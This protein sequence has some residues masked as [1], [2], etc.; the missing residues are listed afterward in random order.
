LKEEYCKLREND[1]SG[2]GQN[3][4]RITVRQ[5]E[6]MIRLSE[7]LAK[8]QFEKKVKE[9]HVKEASRL[10]RKSIIHVDTVDLILN[11]NL[12]NFQQNPRNQHTLLFDSQQIDDNED[13]DDTPERI[14]VSYEER[15]K[16]R[17]A[18]IDYFHNSQSNQVPKD[19]LINWYLVN[20][21]DKYDSIKELSHTK[22]IL[23][24][25]IDNLVEEQDLVCTVE[26]GKEIISLNAFL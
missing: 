20:Q 11:E 6:S 18:F 23:I 15:E 16:I 8:L 22:E 24:L 10:L 12:V 5:L 4:Y 1:V 25:V 17:E 2:S 13:M 14:V 21:V 9:K 26:D 19:E 7:A 3:S